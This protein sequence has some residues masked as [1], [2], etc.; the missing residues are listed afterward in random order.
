MEREYGIPNLWPY[1]CLDRVVM[2]GLGA[3]EYP[4][5]RPKYTHEEMMKILQVKARAIIKFFEEERPDFLILTVV[6]GIAQMLLYQ[7]AKRRGIKIIVIMASLVGDNYTISE[8]CK[9]LSWVVKLFDKYISDNITS[10]K[11]EEA[12]HY[13]TKFREKPFAYV[14]SLEDLDKKNSQWDKFLW[15]LPS[16]FFKSLS[17]FIKFTVKYI[18][19]NQHDYDEE[20][21]F[22]YFIDG[23]KR[24]IRTLIGFNH[25]YDKVNFE[26]NFAFFPLHYEPEIALLLL[27]PFWTN[28][29]NLIRQIA[30]SLP[31]CFKLYVKEHP[32]M[33]GYRTHAYY[34]ELKKIPNVKLLNPSL[35]SF[36]IIKHSRL[37][38]T[39]TGTVG[40]EALLCKKPVITF[41]D[42]FYNKLSMVKRCRNI[43]ELPFIVK[44]QLE[45]FKHNEF[46]LENFIGALME[47]SVPVDLLRIWERGTKEEHEEKRRLTLL[48]DLMAKKLNLT[49]LN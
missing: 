13:I 12:R 42:V 14:F 31:L 1:I 15:F 17:W 18:L 7:I 34:R 41:G 6:G 9:N 48:V 47:E 27:A 4:Y 3:R 10:K 36:D 5:D 43:E 45:N 46:E 37:V 21:P 35:K 25:L 32:L 2:S 29:I 11:I 24:K 26:E 16:R 38:L 22:G 30:K 33:V 23:V 49:P 19:K 39:I 44:D 28:Q 40:L 20:I 8:D